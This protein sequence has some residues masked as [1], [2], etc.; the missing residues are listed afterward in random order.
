MAKLLD[1]FTFVIIK[2]IQITFSVFDIFPIKIIL[3]NEVI[4][5]ITV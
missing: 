3:I 4:I 1:N 5:V 2:V